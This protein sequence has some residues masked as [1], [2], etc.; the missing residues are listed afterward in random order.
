MERSEPFYDFA[1][2]VEGVVCEAFAGVVI[3]LRSPGVSVS[4]CVLDF[5]QGCASFKA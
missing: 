2:R 4:C 3:A 1:K 5:V